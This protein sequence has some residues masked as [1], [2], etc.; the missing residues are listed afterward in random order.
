VADILKQDEVR[1]WGQL[2]GVDTVRFSRKVREGTPG[3]YCNRRPS[4]PI[5]LPDAEPSRKERG[6]RGVRP[7]HLNRLGLRV[8]RGGFLKAARDRV[9]L[10]LCSSQ[11]SC[12]CAQR[13]HFDLPADV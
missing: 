11:S 2:T 7:R 12:F 9:F 8:R 13:E 6:H 3:G 10:L 4:L 5:L 1:I